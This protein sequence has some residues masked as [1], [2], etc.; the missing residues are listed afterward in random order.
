MACSSHCAP[1]HVERAPT[2]ALAGQRLSHRRAPTTPLARRR[3]P[4][5]RVPTEAVAVAEAEAEARPAAVAGATALT[6][7]PPHRQPLLTGAGQ[8]QQEDRHKR[9]RHVTPA[10][11]RRRRAA[12]GTATRRATPRTAASI[13]AAPTTRPAIASV[14]PAVPRGT[15]PAV[16]T[17]AILGPGSGRHATPRATPTRATMPGR[18]RGRRASAK[19]RPTSPST[20]PI[21]TSTWPT[22]SKSRRPV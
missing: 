12:T 13:A 1:S 4:H 18:V 2:T 19:P 8:C 15:S 3:L 11:A 20:R 7:T 9:R 10:A 21:I 14:R 6:T 5:R 17:R 16:T 22:R